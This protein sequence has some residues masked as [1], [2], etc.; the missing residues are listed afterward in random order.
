MGFFDFLG[1]GNQT[2]T[3]SNM[4][5][6]YLRPLLSNQAKRA[7][8]SSRNFRD[9]FPGQTYAGFNPLQENAM[10]GMMQGARET[11]QGGRRL[12]RQLNNFIK[13]PNQIANNP[14][15]KRMMNANRRSV[16][17]TLQRDMMP[18]IERGASAAGQLGSTRQGIAEGIAMGDAAGEIASGNANIM[19]NAYGDATKLAGVGASLMP[20]TYNMMKDPANTEMQIGGMRQGMRQ[21]AIDERMQRYYYPEERK[22]ELMGRESQVYNG[23][24]GYG[25]QS[26]TAPGTSPLAGALGGGMAG[27]GAMTNLASLTGGS[28]PGLAGMG[29]MGAIAPWIGIPAL[30]GALG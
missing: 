9:F 2:T 6:K 8:W 13:A 26:T 12:N 14:A 20:Q 27:L 4:P 25:T 18:G 24:G 29:A 11:R 28:V 30:L 16:M 5:P 19:S 1:G 7:N 22:W 23:Q 15:V 21:K 3:V 10:Q 17:D